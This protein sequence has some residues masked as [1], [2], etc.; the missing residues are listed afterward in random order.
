MMVDVMV[1]RWENHL[2][3][4]MGTSLVEKKVGLKVVMKVPSLAG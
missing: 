3:E 2:V 4:Q 1:V